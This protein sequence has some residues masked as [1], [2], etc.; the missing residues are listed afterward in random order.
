MFTLPYSPRHQLVGAFPHLSDVEAPVR[1]GRAVKL[2]DRMPNLLRLAATALDWIGQHPET[3]I[4]DPHQWHSP[5]AASGRT[6]V[7]VA[8]AL[9]AY[10]GA[11]NP[12][13][14]VYPNTEHAGAY[15][16]LD[17]LRGHGWSRLANPTPQMIE[18]MP[19]LEKMGGRYA[20]AFHEC[21]RPLRGMN[22]G[23]AVAND[24]RFYAEIA[25]DV[26]D[27]FGKLPARNQEMDFRRVYDPMHPAL[28]VSY[29][30]GQKAL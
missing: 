18:S 30:D 6:H 15:M 28:F 8:G 11:A 3:Y 19:S 7:C 26:L 13:D 9:M 20:V 1:M 14:N 17:A 27:A 22:Q 12:K 16:A 5:S 29:A 2:P 23:W 21:A 10:K 24:L 4:Y 25:R